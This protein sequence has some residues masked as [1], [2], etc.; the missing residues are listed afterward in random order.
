[1]ISAISE[2][3]IALWDLLGK[4]LGAPIYKLLGGGA[5][6]IK[7]YI[8]GE[9]HRQGKGVKELVE[10]VKNYVNQGFKMVKIKV[11]GLELSKDIKRLKAL[12]E[13]FGETLDIAVDANN[14]Y[15][16][17]EALRARREFGKL[18][19]VFF[20]EP[21]MTDHLDL[22]AELVRLLEIPVAGYETAYIL[23][24]SREII[25]MKAVDIVQA[26][27]AWSGG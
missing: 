8:T 18:G 5:K 20:E 27:A 1:M 17:N 12:R 22:S 7:G 14:V 6:R 25:T 15:T 24:E 26:D 4:E 16:F 2:V 23:F 10:E 3:D 21:I 19:V 13:E 11:G 9:Y